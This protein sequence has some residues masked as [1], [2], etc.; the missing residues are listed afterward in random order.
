MMTHPVRLNWQHIQLNANL[1]DHQI[2]LSGD[3]DLQDNGDLKF[4]LTVPNMDK[5]KPQMTGTLAVHQIDLNFLQA[6][7]GEFSQFHTV[8]NSQ[9]SFSGPFDHPN[10]KGHLTLNEMN[11]QGEMTP[12]DIS[13]GK[14]VI[15]FNGYQADGYAQVETPGGSLHL[16]GDADWTAIESWKIGAHLY[17]DGVAVDLPPRVHLKAVPDLMLTMTPSLAKV[18]GSVS[19]PEGQIVVEALPSNAVRVSK[20]QVIVDSSHQPIK[21]DRALPIRLETDVTVKL[22]DQVRLSAFGLKGRL[23]GQLKVTQRDQAPFI[24]GD[25]NIFGGTYRSF[26]QDL[27]IKQGKILMNGPVNQPYVSITAIRNPDNI[28]DNVTAGIQVTGPAD[29]PSVSI[30]SDPVMPQ[31]NALSYLLRGQ[32]LDA[33]SG[34]NAITS[35]LIGLSLAQSGKVVGEIG[36]AFGVQDLQLDTSGAGDASQVTVSGYILPDCKSNMVLV[37]LIRL[38]N[39]RCV[40]A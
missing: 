19:L 3:V 34:G 27:V 1:K 31:A 21:K 36:Q 33:E 30:F 20:D 32:D 14:V 37:F 24:N 29:H 15:Q 25:V 18:E 12:V 13:Q 39:S 28:Q 16:K 40:I 4:N 17:A 10:L 5:P 11:I 38:V 23:Q 26:G 9:V 7:I 2:S 35:S 8:V 22:G 6:L